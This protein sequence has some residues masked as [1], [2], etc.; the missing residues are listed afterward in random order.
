MEMRRGE[1][2]AWLTMADSYSV[3]PVSGLLPYEVYNIHTNKPV[4]SFRDMKDAI[5]HA[6]KLN[7]EK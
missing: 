5:W 7:L 6:A 2:L 4:Q 1:Y 3:R